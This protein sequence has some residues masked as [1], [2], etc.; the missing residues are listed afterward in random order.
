MSQN[1]VKK[2][3]SRR[4]KSFEHRPFFDPRLRPSDYHSCVLS[5]WKPKCIMAI[6]QNTQSNISL[7]WN[8]I[9]TIYSVLFSGFNLRKYKFTQD[10]LIPNFIISQLLLYLFSGASIWICIDISVNVYSTGLLNIP[11]TISLLQ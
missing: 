3:I 1:R 11:L 9:I 2:E 8:M 4:L 6:M 7:K 5:C 10:V